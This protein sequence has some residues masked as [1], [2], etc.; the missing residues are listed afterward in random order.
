M[1]QINLL[2]NNAEK[3]L[4][5]VEWMQEFFDFLQG[6][7]PEWLHLSRGHIPKMSAKKAFS[8][9]YYLQEHL[10]VFPDSIELCWNCGELFDTESEG[11][12]WQAKGRHY[13][14][15]CEDQVPRNY[16]RGLS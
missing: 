13:C 9:I 15:A 1:D 5:D 16:D 6:D 3:E 14:G 2:K 12:H 8:I 7:I 10:S 11:L 4:S